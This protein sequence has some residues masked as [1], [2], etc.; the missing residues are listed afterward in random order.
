MHYS[1]NY[2][3]GPEEGTVRVYG[4]CFVTGNPY[5]VVVPADGF[6]AWREGGLIQDHLPDV[7]VDDREFLISGTSPEGWNQ[8][9][10][11]EE[12]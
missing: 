1:L 8:M 5:S 7:S 9:F 3:D 10:P 4:N 2:T 6:F 11:A 12:V